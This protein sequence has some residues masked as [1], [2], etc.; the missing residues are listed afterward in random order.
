MG[1]KYS[2]T[3]IIPAYWTITHPELFFVCSHPAATSTG[4]WWGVC[5][6]C[7][8]GE[9]GTCPRPPHQAWPHSPAPQPSPTA[10]RGRR[11]VSSLPLEPLPTPEQPAAPWALR[12][13]CESLLG[14]CIYPSCSP[15][16]SVPL[17]CHGAPRGRFSPIRRHEGTP[18]GPGSMG[19][20]TAWKPLLHAA[21]ASPCWGSAR[22]QCLQGKEAGSCSPS[23]LL[24]GAQFVSSPCQ[25]HLELCQA[26]GWKAGSCSPCPPTQ[27]GKSG[28]K[29]HFQETAALGCQET[30]AGAEPGNFRAGDNLPPTPSVM[31]RLRRLGY[32]RAPRLPCRAQPRRC[33]HGP[34]LPRAPPNSG[35]G[36]GWGD[37]GW[38]LPARRQLPARWP[39]QR[40]GG[41]SCGEDF[42]SSAFIS[43]PIWAQTPRFQRSLGRKEPAGVFSS[44]TGPVCFCGVKTAVLPHLE[45]IL[46]RNTK[47]EA[48]G[49]PSSRAR[50]PPAPP[51]AAQPQSGFS[52]ISAPQ[53]EHFWRGGAGDGLAQME[54]ADGKWLQSSPTCSDTPAPSRRC[55][56][57]HPLCAPQARG[58]APRP[59]SPGHATSLR[60]SPGLRSLAAY[61][62]SMSNKSC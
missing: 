22:D 3:F 26:G 6:S 25:H 47:G 43:V 39:R 52:I 33:R 60:L 30:R 42:S 49:K 12:F 46:C 56:D 55:L 34:P 15:R 1:T 31:R 32:R 50:R 2:E 44:L 24:R 23:T 7:G 57:P 45:E 35:G 27:D 16:A 29:L 4:G 20:A 61:G 21:P 19:T 8:W 14:G 38:T 58:L 17:I 5:V 53:T 18:P 41:N 37:A 59:P 51:W 11:A 13:A 48:A 9:L 28:G 62:V 36:Q 10:E 40:A 54:A